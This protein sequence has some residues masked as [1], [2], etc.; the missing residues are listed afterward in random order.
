MEAT[1]AMMRSLLGLMAVLVLAGCK[2]SGAERGAATAKPAGTPVELPECRRFFRIVTDKALS[3][4]AFSE[5]VPDVSLAM[6]SKGK[7]Q[8]TLSY[9][10]FDYEDA[11]IEGEWWGV[12]VVYARE[13]QA[14]APVAGGVI[15]MSGVE[16][17]SSGGAVLERRADGLYLTVTPLDAHEA[18]PRC[19]GGYVVKLDLNGV[20]YAD[21]MKIGSIR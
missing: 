19:R 15:W 9:Q 1:D 18:P 12:G 7:G 8:A 11:P 6:E 14:G 5:L 17:P 10:G 16:L 3:L 13:A 20:L 2:P 21:G 4:E